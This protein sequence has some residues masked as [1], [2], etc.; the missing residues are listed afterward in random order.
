MWPGLT[1]LPWT[2]FAT[3]PPR[4]LPPHAQEQLVTKLDLADRYVTAHY[5]DGTYC[6][7][8]MT[9]DDP[10]VFTVWVS[11]ASTFD[12]R[13]D[14]DG[15]VVRLCRVCAPTDPPERR[16]SCPD[17]GQTIRL[18]GASYRLLPV[19]VA[20][21]AIPWAERQR[22]QPFASLFTDTA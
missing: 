21:P 14:D 20:D 12:L 2:A 13:V 4:R 15:T 16:K 3:R 6:Y 22:R 1:F 7:M 10:A 8:T 18:M 17:C 19:P 5:R 9:T 11:D